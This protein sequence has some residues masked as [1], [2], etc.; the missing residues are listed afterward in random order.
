[1]ARHFLL[2]HL[3]I[4]HSPAKVVWVECP[5]KHQLK[6]KGQGLKSSQVRVEHQG[7]LQNEKM[8]EVTFIVSADIGHET[9]SSVLYT[10]NSLYEMVMETS[11]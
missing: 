2:V 5:T 6:I 1:M 9:Q 8:V 7:Y 3:L 11:S 10:F 4:K